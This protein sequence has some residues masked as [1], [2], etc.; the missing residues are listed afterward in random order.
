VRRKVSGKTKAIVANRLAQLHR[1]LEAGAL[2][3]MA[4]SNSTAG[5]AMVHLALK[6]VIR[7]GPPVR[8][9]QRRRFRRHPRRTARPAQQIPTSN[10]QP[11]C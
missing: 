8:H 11:P 6:R 5:V 3:H 2:A 10:N 7:P 9:H 4:D 1:D